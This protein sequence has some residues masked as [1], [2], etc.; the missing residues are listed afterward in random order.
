MVIKMKKY[1]FCIESPKEEKN[2]KSETW[3][4][5]H[6]QMRS[7]IL[8]HCDVTVAPR[9]QKLGQKSIWDE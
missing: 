2:L 3:P 7:G 9:G 5:T 8:N 1:K 6:Y 4:F